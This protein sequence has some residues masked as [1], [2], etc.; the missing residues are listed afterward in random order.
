MRILIIDE[1]HQS[2]FVDMIPSFLKKYNVL[3]LECFDFIALNNLIKKWF[4]L[5]YCC[6]IWEFRDFIWSGMLLILPISAT[7]IPLLFKKWFLMSSLVW[8][9]VSGVQIMTK[10]VPN[11]KE[12]QIVDI[13]YGAVVRDF[14]SEAKTRCNFQ[15]R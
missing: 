13:S 3:D 15:F 10:T 6:S 2:S 4:Y 1:F 8:P 9:F 14:E 5:D 12:V 11:I 7:I